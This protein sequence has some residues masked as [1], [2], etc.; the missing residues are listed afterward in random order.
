MKDKMPSMLGKS[1]AKQKA[2]TL[3]PTIFMCVRLHTYIHNVRMNVPRTNP[4]DRNIFR[5]GSLDCVFMCSDRNFWMNLGWSD[6]TFSPQIA[7]LVVARMR[8]K[9]THP[10]QRKKLTHLTKVA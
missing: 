1:S 2:G 6:C 10:I 8:Y 9:F 7:N 3:H 4:F 5:G